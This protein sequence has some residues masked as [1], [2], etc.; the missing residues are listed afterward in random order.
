MWSP[1]KNSATVKGDINWIKNCPLK[2]LKWHYSTVRSG[3]AVAVLI[4]DGAFALSFVSSSGDLTAQESLPPGIYHPRQKINANAQG[5][6]GVSPGRGLV[7]AGIDWCKTDR[8]P[9]CCRQQWSGSDNPFMYRRTATWLAQ[10]DKLRS[11]EWEAVGS[12]PGRTN[13]QGL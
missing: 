13:P 2:C 6:G 7:A 3:K 5:L 1:N 4:E 11:T 12:N 10:W 8:M 9:C